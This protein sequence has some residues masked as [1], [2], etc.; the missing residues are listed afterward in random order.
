MTEKLKH[1]TIKMKQT[2]F[3]STP[4]SLKNST[5]KSP[6]LLKHTTKTVKSIKKKEKS[7]HQKVTKLILI[8]L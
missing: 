3:K 5:I 4:S 6:N 2:M 7:N 1:N 8:E